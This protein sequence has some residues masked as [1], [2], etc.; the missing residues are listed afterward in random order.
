MNSNRK[1]TTI[2]GVL[3][4]AGTIAGILSIAPAI[5]AADYLTKAST[6][7]NQ[8]LCAGLFQFIMT[9]AYT[10]YAIALFPIIRKYK[11]GL[12][13]GFLSFRIIAAVLNSIGYLSL[14]LL[15]SLSQEFVKTGTPDSSYFQ[16]LGDLL[17]SGRDFVNH[18]SM[19]L[20]TSVGG[21]MF[22]FLLYQT[23]L[24]PR[25]LSF[26]GLSGTVFTIFASFLIMFHIIDIITT[27]YIAL[28]LPLIVLEMFLAL[29]LIV[30]GF[31]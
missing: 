27:I 15:L 21:L 5:D 4:I 11:E 8:V 31:D 23:K 25:W 28:N 13:L 26:W 17:R 12:A 2:A 1:K 24:I 22:Y 3:Y 14:L 6:H 19:I 9:I 20:T 29:W 7:T 18:V 30:K 16:I 10:G